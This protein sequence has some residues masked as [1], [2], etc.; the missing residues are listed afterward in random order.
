MNDPKPFVI[1][2]SRDAGVVCGYLKL[3]TPTTG[4][5]AVV[6]LDEARQIWNWTG[7]VNTL[8]EM[9]NHGLRQARISLPMELT[10]TMFGVCGVYQCTQEAEANLRQSRWEKDYS[11]SA[12]LPSSK[13]RSDRT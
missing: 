4:G 1:C 8:M 10:F 6:E 13:K 7:G 2:R 5:L 3:M 11:P 12:N 9:A